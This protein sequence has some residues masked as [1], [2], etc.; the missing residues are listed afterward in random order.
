MLRSL[1]GTL[2]TVGGRSAGDGKLGCGGGTPAATA[3][4]AAAAAKLSP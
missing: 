1:G 3:A 4:A 2:A